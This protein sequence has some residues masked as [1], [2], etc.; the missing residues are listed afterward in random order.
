MQLP[1]LPA[2]P[3]R[4]IL[5]GYTWARCGHCGEEHAVLSTRS[6]LAVARGCARF[7]AV[8]TELVRRGVD[9]FRELAD[10]TVLDGDA[11]TARGTP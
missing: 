6:D 7:R 11:A 3:T 1:L 4:T 5:G 10:G 9:T 2:A 8:N